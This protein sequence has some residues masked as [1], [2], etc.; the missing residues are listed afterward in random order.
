VL[1]VTVDFST[2]S[3]PHAGDDCDA[4]FWGLVDDGA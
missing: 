1:D 4:D 3:L 2:L